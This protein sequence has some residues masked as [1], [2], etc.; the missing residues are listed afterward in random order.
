M[1][2]VGKTVAGLCALCLLPPRE[3]PAE[4]HRLA[5]FCSSPGT[6]LPLLCTMNCTVA[7]ETIRKLFKVEVKDIDAI[8]SDAKPGSDGMMM[9]PFFN[10]ER[11][12]DYPHG[13]G[14]LFG[15]RQSNVKKENI[16]RAA[17]EGVTYEFLLGLDAFRE[18]GIPVKEL[19]LTGGG[20]KSRLWRK[21]VSDMT[22][23]PV[24]VPK[25]SESAAFGAALHGLWCKEGGKIEELVKSHVEYDDEKAVSP[26]AND[27]EI[28][29]A[30]YIR[31]LEYS[32]T[33]SPIFS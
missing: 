18:N 24:K 1:K 14:V 28:Y 26:D 3:I 10:G 11:V 4:A 31:W 25:T 19:I 16:M 21:I 33:L 29:K 13:E 17:M 22:F 32:K 20:A 15:M 6:Y 2:R 8:A 9:L 5:S 7:T 27:N 23:C 30:E 12:P